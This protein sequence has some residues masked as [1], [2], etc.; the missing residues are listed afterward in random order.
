MHTAHEAATEV[1]FIRSHG[2]AVLIAT[3]IDARTN[4]W[5][6]AGRADGAVGIGN[7]RPDRAPRR[8]AGFY[9]V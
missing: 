6:L 7:C 3:G 9:P 8:R 2:G 1:A 4:A 5:S